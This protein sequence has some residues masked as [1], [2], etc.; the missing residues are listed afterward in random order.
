MGEWGDAFV[1]TQSLKGK[2]GLFENVSLAP[3]TSWQVGGKARYVYK[4]ETKEDLAA[5]LKS[6][7]ASE[8]LLVMGLGS[9]LL[10]REAG[11]S[12]TIIL[13]QGGLSELKSVDET[14]VFAQAGVSCAQLAR[15]S[16]RQHLRHLEF[17]A[18]VPGTVGGALAM[19]AGCHGNETWNQVLRVELVTRA[20]EFVVKEASE[21][22]IA[23]RHVVL[24]ENTWFIG[25]CFKGEIGTKEEALKEINKLLD[26]RV[27]TQPTHQPSC[28]SVFRNPPGHY[29]AKLIESCGLKGICIGGAQV[30]PKHANFIVNLGSATAWDIEQLIAHVKKT[31]FEKTGVM[32]ME[33]VRMV[34]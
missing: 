21:F 20:G 14:T 26:Y 1:M 11:F 23:Y 28:G 27:R 8:P 24:P 31:V 15:F 5:F 17:L 18:G 4:P 13:I 7:P 2:F 19:N 32:M 3:L 34:G 12:G 6:L 22:E 30:S 29:A 33:E 9:N 25:G 16:A 10:V